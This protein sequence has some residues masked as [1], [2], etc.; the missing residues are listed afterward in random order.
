[1]QAVARR[2]VD[3]GVETSLQERLDVNKVECVEPIRL[4]SFDEDVDVAVVAG[5]AAGG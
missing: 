2:Q 1:M 5:Q 4:F 3:M